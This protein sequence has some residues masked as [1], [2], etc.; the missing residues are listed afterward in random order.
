MKRRQIE[1]EFSQYCD[2]YVLKRIQSN[3]GMETR[4]YG[5]KTAMTF[6]Q[7]WNDRNANKIF[8]SQYFL[9]AL[10]INALS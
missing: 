6:K 3:Q 2:E 1:Y 10:P 8:Q 9:V 7:F 4:K 5:N